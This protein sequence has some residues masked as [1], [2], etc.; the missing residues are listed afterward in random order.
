MVNRASFSFKK[1]LLETSLP[2]TWKTQENSG[3]HLA[4]KKV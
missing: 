1:Y 4:K 2:L 3:K